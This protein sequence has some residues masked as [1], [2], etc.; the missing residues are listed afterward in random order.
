MRVVVM[1]FGQ[2]LGAAL[3]LIG[4]YWLLGL[5]W[6][7]VLAGASLLVVC[8]LAELAAAPPRRRRARDREGA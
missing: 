5:A 2:V 6:A 8:T 7:T 3:L 1:V 4:L